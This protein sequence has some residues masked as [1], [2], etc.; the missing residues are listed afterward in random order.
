[1]VNPL[2]IMKQLV[3]WEQ[4]LRGDRLTGLYGR[5][6]VRIWKTWFVTLW[7]GEGIK[8]KEDWQLG[9][10]SRDYYESWP[11]K[12]IVARIR[13]CPLQV[14]WWIKFCSNTIIN[15][16]LKLICLHWSQNLKA[17]KN[18]QWFVFWKTSVAQTELAQWEHKAWVPLKL[19]G[20]CCVW[21]WLREGAKTSRTLHAV[22]HCKSLLSEHSAAIPHWH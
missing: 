5:G 17:G 18:G 2:W 7:C 19:V 20:P 4:C 6:W 14:V 9:N 8:M 13:S 22:I 3:F 16:L 12:R 15:F 10:V 11:S 1:M 21:E